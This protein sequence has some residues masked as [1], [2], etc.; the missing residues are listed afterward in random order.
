MNIC[1]NK[2]LKLQYL[3]LV[4]CSNS[5]LLFSTF[6]L[7]YFPN[8]VKQLPICFSSSAVH[9]IRQISFHVFFKHL[10]MWKQVESIWLT[11]N[12]HKRLFWFLQFKTINF[13]EIY[14]TQN[15]VIL[16]YSSCFEVQPLAI[17]LHAGIL[18]KWFLLLLPASSFFLIPLCC[19][20]FPA[21]HAATCYELLAVTLQLLTHLK[22][23]KY[24]SKQNARP[25]TCS[26]QPC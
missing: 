20:S 6:Q 11:S 10:L 4:C 1:E 3:L 22:M 19:E 18:C 24:L 12:S 16:A 14:I 7:L 25:A 9:K 8:S 17:V 21:T 5:N 13:S 23:F 2:Q 15:I 26:L